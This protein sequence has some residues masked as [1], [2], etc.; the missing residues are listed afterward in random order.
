MTPGQFFYY[1]SD[2]EYEDWVRLYGPEHATRLAVHA[3]RI[4]PRLLLEDPT[5]GIEW[6]ENLWN[7]IFHL[8]RRAKH[9]A[10]GIASRC[11]LTEEFVQSV[12]DGDVDEQ[13]FVLGLRCFNGRIFNVD[14]K[15]L[16]ELTPMQ[17]DFITAFNDYQKYAHLCATE[18]GWWDEERNDGECIALMHSELSEA[19]EGMR[20]GNPE[21]QKLP[22]V[23]SVEEE[24]ADVVIRI[25]DYSQAAG[26]NIADAIVTKVEFNKNREHRHGK[27]F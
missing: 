21:S 25:M 2:D 26:L 19:L 6:R 5:E 4:R 11:S 17:A 16:E 14:M 23:S 27:A 8:I 12:M 1:V 13:L 22:G 3:D 15:E 10:K 18:R 9:G 24:L 7:R 20:Y